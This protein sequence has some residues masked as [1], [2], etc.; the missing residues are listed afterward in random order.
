MNVQNLANV[1]PDPGITQTI[2]NTCDTIGVDT[3]T[4]IGPLAKVISTGGNTYFDQ[5]FGTLWLVYALQVAGFNALAQTPT[6]IPQTETGV[7]YL[8]NAYTGVL[9]QGVTNGFMAPGA[10]NSPVTFGNPDT[11]RNA[12]LTVGFFVYSIPV[13][14]QSQA[15]RVAR[16]APL[17]QIAAKLA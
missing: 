11:L 14:L 13:N 10:W 1:L 9:E 6:K 12:I 3:Y 7:A 2:K 5:V 16:Q 4:N 17:I 8:R 15:N